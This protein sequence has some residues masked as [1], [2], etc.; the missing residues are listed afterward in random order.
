MRR[1]GPNG[2][3]AKLA[4]IANENEDPTLTPAASASDLA[5]AEAATDAVQAEAEVAESSVEGDDI[6]NTIDDGAEAATALESMIDQLRIC[7]QNGGLSKEAAGV[8]AIQM[9]YMRNNLGLAGSGMP[10]IESFGTTTGRISATKISVESLGEQLKEVWKNIINAIKKAIQ[11]V[12]DHFFKV[13]GAA[14]RMKKRAQ[15]IVN[16]QAPTGTVKEAVVENGKLA[17]TLAVGAKLEAGKLKDELAKVVDLSKAVLRTDVDYK[18]TLADGLKSAFESGGKGFD[19]DAKFTMAGGSAFAGKLVAAKGGE[20]V[21]AVLGAS[22][23]GTTWVG[24]DV[25]PG[26]QKFVAAVASS[27]EPVKGVA[28]LKMFTKYR[29][30]FA[31]TQKVPVKVAEKFEVM[32]A[33]GDITATAEEV[34]KLAD[35]VIDFRKGQSTLQVA[36]DEL[37]KVAE[38][39]IKTNESESN[40]ADGDAKNAA[41]AQK[42]NFTE[43]KNALS[44]FTRVYIAPTKLITDYALRVGNA[45]LDVCTISTKRFVA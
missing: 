33:T 44:N 40:G 34:V 45:A 19:A 24:T 43:L 12:K 3:R 8:V 28:A 11:W 15:A 6:E 20:S 29:A 41:T 42:E 17:S 26:N 16:Q 30:Q 18:K 5:V 1:F 4:N 7:A 21:A 36:L 32:K 2:T 35:V 22:P 31:N 10:A 38:T 14:E 27:A 23:E 25:L 37:T 9:S 13:F 39:A